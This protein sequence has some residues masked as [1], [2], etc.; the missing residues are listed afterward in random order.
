MMVQT[1]MCQSK[2]PTRQQVKIRMQTRAQQMR[3]GWRRTQ[4]LWTLNSRRHLQVNS[5]REELN[6]HKADMEGLRVD[7]FQGD[8]EE[9]TEIL[10]RILRMGIRGHGHEKCQSLSRIPDPLDLTVST[11]IR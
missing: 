2:H 10:E 8:H 1:T 4:N 5:I 9:I 3:E 7:D 6:S 11:K